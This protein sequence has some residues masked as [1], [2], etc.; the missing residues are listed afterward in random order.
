MDVRCALERPLTIALR[1]TISQSA[2]HPSVL[3]TEPQQMIPRRWPCCGENAE[4][5]ASELN[6]LR[7]RLAEAEGVMDGVKS[8]LEWNEGG[9]YLY[10]Q[11]IQAVLSKIEAYKYKHLKG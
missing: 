9:V 3:D 4:R 6:A 2:V 8:V 1:V 7:S 5:A 11:K 10:A